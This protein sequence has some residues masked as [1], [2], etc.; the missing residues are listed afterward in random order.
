MGLLSKIFI[1]EQKVVMFLENSA[2]STLYSSTKVKRSNFWIMVT[3]LS[4]GNTDQFMFKLYFIYCA[5]VKEKVSENYFWVLN[6][7]LFAKECIQNRSFD[8]DLAF[9]GSITQN[10]SLGSR[11]SFCQ[12]TER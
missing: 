4:D 8:F 9:D 1:C 2:Q 10:S 11:L 5:A 12:S 7:Q 3:C 6:T